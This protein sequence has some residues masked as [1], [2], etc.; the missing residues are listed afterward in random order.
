[1]DVVN[2]GAASGPVTEC[3]ALILALVHCERGGATTSHDATRG[4]STC[5]SAPAEQHSH[6]GLTSGSCAVRSR[7][8]EGWGDSRGDNQSA[9]A[10][11]PCCAA[12][13]HRVDRPLAGAR[14]MP[15]EYSIGGWQ[16]NCRMGSEG[17]I[18]GGDSLAATFRDL[19]VGWR[20]TRRKAAGAAESGDLRSCHRYRRAVFAGLRLT[21]A[22]HDNE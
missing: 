10:V 5:N 6:G 16:K 19:H 22:E 7:S 18:K 21:A 12:L 14:V 13:V 15:D 3:L 11:T 20:G 1:M 4:Q 2:T 8:I 9:T 17:K